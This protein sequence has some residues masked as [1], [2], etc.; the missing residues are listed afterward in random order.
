MV[1]SLFVSVSVNPQFL[2]DKDVLYRHS[3]FK[4]IGICP[5]ANSYIN[6]KISSKTNDGKG[7][8]GDGGG[9]GGGAGEEQYKITINNPPKRVKKCQ[10]M[11]KT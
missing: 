2:K 3:L 10:Y 1:F 9:G 5:T 4:L 8:G 7:G 6:N 11:H